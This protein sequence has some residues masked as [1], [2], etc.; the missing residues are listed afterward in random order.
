MNERDT[1]TLILKDKVNVAGEVN[2]K[3]IRF[4]IPLRKMYVCQH[5]I[6]EGPKPRRCLRLTLGPRSRYCAEHSS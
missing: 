2:I 1:A 3:T 4:R 5:P 6:S